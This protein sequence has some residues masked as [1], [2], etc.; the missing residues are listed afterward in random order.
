MC[1][2]VEY[3]NYTSALVKPNL[4]TNRQFKYFVILLPVINW[5]SEKLLLV[6]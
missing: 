6:N 2:Q 1:V 3:K 4:F 5:C